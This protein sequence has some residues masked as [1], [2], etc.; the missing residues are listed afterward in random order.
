MS[1]PR[2][3][4]SH[5]GDETVNAVDARELHVK[6][7]VGRD[8]SNWIKGRLDELSAFFREGFDYCVISHPPDPANGNPRGRT[9]YLLS[10]DVAKHLSMMERNERGFEIRQGFIDFEKAA[11]PALV[12]PAFDPLAP[13]TVLAV[14]SAHVERVKV[15][16]S[17]NARLAAV[18]EDAAPK[19]AIVDRLIECGDTL[20]F[21]A[22]AKLVFEA[23]GAKESEFRSLMIQRGWIQRLDG[24]LMPAHAGT[25]RGYVVT[26]E[27][28]WTEGDGS[29]HVRPE[30]R[31]TQKGL[32]RAVAL[33]LA[34]EAAE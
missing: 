6:L 27:R 13:S 16:E 28:E 18:V 23:T 15:L 5:I 3:L 30:M 22:A 2:I 26:R 21:R 11:R 8:F 19:V 31:V 17:D 14:L 4:R 25:S 1:L 20:G 34:S 10:L 29:R 24:S 7:G 33:L 32:A 12:A 9:E